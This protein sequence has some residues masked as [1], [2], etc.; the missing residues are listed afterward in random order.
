GSRA[1][2][3]RDGRR[4]ALERKS[5]ERESVEA[6]TLRRSDAPPAPTLPR[7]HR[8]PLL[9]CQNR[10]ALHQR[11]VARRG[12]A[13]SPPPDVTSLAVVQ[14]CQP[15]PARAA[16]QPWRRKDFLSSFASRI[17]WPPDRRIPSGISGN[18]GRRLSR[19]LRD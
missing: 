15:R 5:V 16:R 2:R 3:P 6:W 11:S 14:S 12:F 9:L 8:A 19:V 17:F 4:T 18:R 7:S 10:S 1:G 13:Q